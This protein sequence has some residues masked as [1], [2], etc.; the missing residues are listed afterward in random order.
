M[1][2]FDD[3]LGVH[4]NPSAPPSPETLPAFPENR[5][6]GTREGTRTPTDEPPEPKSGASANFATR[7]FFNE[8]VFNYNSF[9]P[10]FQ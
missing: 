9:F 3:L 7:A 6:V 2:Q 5:A 4:K 1:Q 8:T 10:C